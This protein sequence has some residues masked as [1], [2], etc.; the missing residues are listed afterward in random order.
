MHH[1]PNFRKAAGNLIGW[2]MWLIIPAILFVS[3]LLVCIVLLL[4]GEMRID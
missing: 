3:I 4:R 2:S 1:Y